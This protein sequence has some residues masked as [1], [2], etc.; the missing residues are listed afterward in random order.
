[1]TVKQC[2]LCCKVS[3]SH[4]ENV[5]GHKLNLLYEKLGIY[6]AIKSEKLDYFGCSFCDLKFF[7]PLEAG[8]EDF[9]VS[10]QNF[11][12]YYMNEKEEFR[13][14]LNWLGN[15]H[16]V[17]DVGA[18]RAAFSAY[19]DKDNYIGLEFNDA[20]I[21]KANALGVNLLKE[22]VEEHA[23]ANGKKYDSV[24]SFQVLE[25]LSSPC[26]FIQGCIDCLKPGGRLILSVP[27]QDGFASLSSN[28]TLDMPP[29]HVTH[30]SEKTLREVAII[31]GLKCL[32]IAHEPV[33][34]Y[35]Y[36]WAK[37]LVIQ[38]WIKKKLGIKHRL[39]EDRLVVELIERISNKLS[40]QLDI[41]LSKIKGH[42]VVAVYETAK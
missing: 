23:K 30:W 2:P 33:A 22:S 28:H 42:T 4:L 17:L 1:M 32:S 21:R 12:W 9:Y 29:H 11:D 41:N 36:Q 8:D 25:H 13:I 35:H 37:S 20:A 14:A 3:A 39:L 38:S 15:N 16:K 5:P 27:S 40:T 10:L 26:S 6:N 7:D 18:G 24:V 34:P 19:L 31:F